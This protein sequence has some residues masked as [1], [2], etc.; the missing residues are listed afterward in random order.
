MILVVNELSYSQ[1][2][3][4]AEAKLW[5]DTFFNTCI[6]LERNFKNKVTLIYSTSIR[7]HAFNV[8]YSFGNWFNALEND[9]KSSVLAMLTEH[10]L[11]H[12][13]PYYKVLGIEGK[14]IGYAFETEDLLISVKSDKKWEV[15]TLEVAREM[16]NEE[17]LELEIDNKS[18]NH[19][20]DDRSRAVHNYY[21][22][23]R[24]RD[25][26]KDKLKEITNGEVLWRKRQLLFPNLIFCDT[27]ENDIK[28]FSG[29]SI[30]CLRER[31][32]EFQEYF[33]QWV[34]GDFDYTLLNGDVRLE[35]DRRINKF[36][37]LNI[38]CPDGKYRLFSYHCNW[39]QWGYRMHF[40][41]D[42]KNHNCIIGYIGRKI[43]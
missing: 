24:I 23:K 43:V 32:N 14:G 5:Y 30:I 41:P 22:N 39:W 42:T 20:Y 1:T 17:T 16:L 38:M 33:S 34:D 15:P 8:T 18:L 36:K 37:Q 27:I 10:P 35:S 25:L 11:L 4:S 26:Q 3:S 6:S 40:Y 31:L 19:F 12:D 2:P 7:N 21:I 29:H 9:L 28:S 13:Y